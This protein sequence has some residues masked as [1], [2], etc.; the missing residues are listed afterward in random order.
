MAA[1]SS[2]DIKRLRVSLIL[3]AVFV[4]LGAGAVYASLKYLEQATKTR[5][6]ALAA[7]KDVMGKLAKVSDE[8]KELRE[9][10][11][12]YLALDARGII[13]QEHRLDWIEQVRRTEKD[14]KL[15]KIDYELSPQQPIDRGVA[16]PSGS[17]VDVLNSRMKFTMPLLHE[18]DLLNLLTDLTA[19]VKAYLRLNSCILTRTP[20]P[21]ERGP[22]PQLKAECELDW[23]TLR[24][25]K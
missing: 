23:I 13:G 16:T 10:L 20:Q 8:E 18:G 4:A 2:Q 11:A 9:K 3:L 1:I 15:F 25:I 19:N 24:E 5:M 6:A 7:K 14:R 12:R 17:G 22:M 21:A